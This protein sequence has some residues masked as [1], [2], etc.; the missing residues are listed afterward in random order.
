VWEKDLKEWQKRDL[1]NKHYAY[2]WVDGI[3][4]NVRMDEKQCLLVTIGATEDGKKELVTIDCGFRESDLSWTQL[5]TDLKR[6]LNW[7]LET[8]PSG[9]G[10]PLPRRILIAGGNDAG[11]TKRPMC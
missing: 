7:P 11:F 10:K 9:S 5:L 4:C 1:S 8:E 3:H 6:G 2:F